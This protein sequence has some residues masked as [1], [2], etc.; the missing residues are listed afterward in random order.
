MRVFYFV[1]I[2]L[3]SFSIASVSA[4]DLSYKDTISD[5]ARIER[6][7]DEERITSFASNIAGTSWYMEKS[8]AII[9]FGKQDSWGGLIMRDKKS[10]STLIGSYTIRAEKH[11]VGTLGINGGKSF[12]FALL[13]IQLTPERLIA[14]KNNGTLISAVRCK[15]TISRSDI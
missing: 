5:F 2:P 12:D 14:Y 1:W 7:S 11:I 10:G 15:Q 8:H 4:K 3:L 13:D 6:F 9:S